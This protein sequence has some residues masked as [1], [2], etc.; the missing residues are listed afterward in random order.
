MSCTEGNPLFSLLLLEEEMIKYPDYLRCST[1]QM[2][3]T[4]N[5]QEFL[6]LEILQSHYDPKAAYTGR[7]CN[8][9]IKAA[10]THK[11]NRYTPC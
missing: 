8:G 2:S 9:L 10:S 11:L 7:V 3:R 6:L 1:I 5:D 4:R